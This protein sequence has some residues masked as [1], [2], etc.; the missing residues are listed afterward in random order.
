MI[1]ADGVAEFD[2]LASTTAGTDHKIDVTFDGAGTFALAVAPLT[3]AIVTLTDFGEGATLDLRNLAF[4]TEETASVSGNHLTIA[5]EQFTLAGTEPTN[6]QVVLISDPFGGTEAVFGTADVWTAGTGDWNAST[7]ENWNNGSGPAPTLLNTVEITTSGITVTLDDTETVGNLVLGAPE[8]GGPTLE[9]GTGASLLESNAL[10]IYGGQISIDAGASLT[11]LGPIDN[12][13]SITLNNQGDAVNPATL[14]LAFGANHDT[15][16]TLQD[17]GDNSVVNAEGTETL[18]NGTLFIGSTLG[19]YLINDDPLSAGAALVL[20]PNLIVDQTGMAQIASTNATITIDDEVV[21]FA[22]IN[23]S[24]NS[25][26]FIQPD[27]FINEGTINANASGA[28]LDIIPTGS[29]TNFG[30]VAVSG[31]ETAQIENGIFSASQPEGAANETTGVI[32]V[33]G[34]GSSLSINSSTFINAGLLEATNGGALD[35]Q[36]GTIV[37]N[38]GTIE[39]GPVNSGSVLTLES[40]TSITGNGTVENDGSIVVASGSVADIAGAVGGTGAL[41]I[42]AAAMLELGSTSTNTVN[43]EGS[44][45]TLQIDSSGTATPYSVEGGGVALPTSAII[46]L[47]NISFDLAADTYS[48]DVITVSNGTASGTVTIDVVGGIGANTFTFK[49]DGHGG[50]EIFDPPPSAPGAFLTSVPEPIAAAD[51]VAAT[52]TTYNGAQAE[53]GL[54]HGTFSFNV[55]SN[56]DGST[57]EFPLTDAQINLAPGQTATQAYSNVTAPNLQNP[58]QTTTGT[59]SVSIGGPGDDNFIFAPGMG[60]DTIVNFNPQ[61]DTIELEHFANLQNV[62]Q[63]AALVTPDAHGDAVIELGHNDSIT[64]PGVTQSYLQ[65]HLQSLVHLG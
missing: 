61:A 57:F 42:G 62:Q 19:S 4:S 41:N 32:S 24:V 47:P 36:A 51:A 27:F 13:G 40:G 45:G 63:L 9:I 29:F 33:D 17:T 16:G 5:G 65:A 56:V 31:G 21:S 37:Q 52:W 11:V 39:V 6:G 25:T 46:D 14:T 30:T 22:T 26:F 49:S 20:G 58:T 7:F 44:T 55:V 35:I 8:A 3:A 1:T 34:V 50:T 10:D 2:S 43:F 54:N 53:P 12:Q 15:I 28:T 64:L 23:T 48:S 38:S 18:D 60:A 59:M